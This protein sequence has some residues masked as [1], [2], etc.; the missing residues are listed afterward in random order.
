MSELSVILV[1]STNHA[2][3]IEHVL[4]L[5]GISSILIP[6]PRHLSSNC[7]NCL[8]INTS[9]REKVQK[10]LEKQKISIEKIVEL[11]Y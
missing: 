6:I 5:E 2:M 4:N 1:K 3:R 7:G 10:I 8:R 9:D 11:D